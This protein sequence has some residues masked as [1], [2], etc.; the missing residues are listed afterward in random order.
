M[1][2]SEQPGRPW[3]VAPLPENGAAVPTNPS[4]FRLL[5]VLLRE[6]TLIVACAVLTLAAV[7]AVTL[8]LP[9]TY[10]SRASFAPQSPQ[11]AGNLSGLAAQIGVSLGGDGGAE[12]PQFYADFLR[13][14][15]MLRDVATSR[16]SFA[17]DTGPVSGTLVDIVRA[18]GETP[19]LRRERTIERLDNW[20][21]AAVTPKT[22]T[23]TLAVT[24][25]D[26]ALSRQIA[27][28]M[29]AL[30]NRFNL[31]N[32]QTQ[33]AAER[34]FAQ[35]RLAEV[36]A[37]LRAAENRLQAFL[38]QN[39]AFRG[40]A[41][42]EFEAARLQRDVTRAQRLTETLAEAYER[43]KIEAVRDTPLI[44]IIEAPEQPVLPERRR[45]LLKGLLA[46]VAGTLA[47]VVLAFARFVATRA[48]TTASDEYK[49]YAVLKREALGD[50]T[51]PW[52]PIARAFGRRPRARAS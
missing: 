50:L 46:L 18:S 6:R 21:T 31:E 12:S 8:L 40:A 20:I 28:R 3:L 15:P 27:D 37:D 25:R 24:T 29:L 34:R 41:S 7:E 13:S 32:R 9:R 2:P 48:E 5:S 17:T 49:E 52:R 22:G 51:H 4:L 30:I 42:L 16:F 39:R 33:A 44:T 35:Q 14:R 43:A 45:L 36:S 47:G 19:A 10:T 23:V 26:P 11:P 1:N 38:Q